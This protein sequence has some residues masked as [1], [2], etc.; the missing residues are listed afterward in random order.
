MNIGGGTVENPRVEDDR[1]TRSGR[2]LL[3]SSGMLIVAGKCLYCFFK[4]NEESLTLIEFICMMSY[5]Y[6][7]VRYKESGA[8]QV[9]FRRV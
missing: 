2:G 6:V 9:E 7:Q 4:M 3:I 1:G 5:V 8:Q